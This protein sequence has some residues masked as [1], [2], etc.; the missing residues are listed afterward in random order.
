VVVHE[1]EV[2]VRDGPAARIDVDHPPPGEREVHRADG[3]ALVR[4][5][6][7]L[8]IVEGARVV[9]THRVRD[10][11]QEAPPDR[12]RLLLAAVRVELDQRVEEV[13]GERPRADEDVALAADRDERAGRVDF[14][15]AE[16]VADDRGRSGEDLLEPGGDADDLGAG[17]LEHAGP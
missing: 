2:V 5:G 11:E 14:D 9:E 3:E 15:V 10:V 7:A 12:V 4:I 16:E 8:P 13:D 17:G 1:A 6:D